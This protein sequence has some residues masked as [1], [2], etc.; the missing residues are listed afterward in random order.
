MGKNFGQFVILLFCTTNKGV[1]TKAPAWDVTEVSGG[2]ADKEMP[3][4]T[5]DSCYGE[6]MVYSLGKGQR[7]KPTS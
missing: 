5:A 1:A 6:L 3:S 2:A 4:T 7:V